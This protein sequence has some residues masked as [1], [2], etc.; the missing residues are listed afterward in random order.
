MVQSSLL[1]MPH[2]ALLPKEKESITDIIDKNAVFYQD[3]QIN[4]D[5]HSLC[6]TIKVDLWPFKIIQEI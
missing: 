4:C 6:Y 2:L 1:F 5:N 3:W